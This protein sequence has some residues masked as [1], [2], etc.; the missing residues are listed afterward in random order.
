MTTDVNEKQV[1]DE[2][3][4]ATVH[5]TLTLSTK[6]KGVFSWLLAYWFVSIVCAHDNWNN[7][8]RIFNQIFMVD[9]I[10]G[11]ERID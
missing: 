9:Y 3:V 8:G 1:A 11:L 5:E 6:E 7:W 2:V 4:A 10:F